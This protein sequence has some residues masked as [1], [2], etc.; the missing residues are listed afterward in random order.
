VAAAALKKNERHYALLLQQSTHQQEQLRRLSRQILSV[1]EA[2]RKRISRELHDVLAQ[3]LTGINLRL[4]ALKEEA[5]VSTRKV[6][7]NIAQTQRLVQRSVT[8]VHRFARELRP[9]VLDDLGLLP[10]LQ[11]CLEQ[12]TQ[13]TGIRTSLTSTPSLEQLDTVRRT[14][15]FRVAQEALSNVSRHAKARHVTVS[16]QEEA[17]QLCMC[18]HDDGRAFDVARA[19][20][21]HGGKRLGLLGMRERLEMVGGSFHVRSSPGAGTHVKACIPL[22][23]LKKSRP[24]QSASP[25]N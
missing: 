13:R 6:N 7:L 9:A 2:E 1:Q 20:Q 23:P 21:A 22:S 24:A 15:L 10:A 11:S 18:I 25:Q 14:A 19:W 17:D 4:S 12:F 8:L 5:N 3:T 16:I